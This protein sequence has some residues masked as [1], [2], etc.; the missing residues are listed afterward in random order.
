MKNSDFKR[1]AHLRE[2]PASAPFATAQCVPVG[3]SPRFLRGLAGLEATTAGLL[4]LESGHQPLIWLLALTLLLHAPLLA[5][6]WRR[7]ARGFRAAWLAP[8]G[9]WWLEAHSGLLQRAHPGGTRF[10]T[11]WW[12]LL[13]LRLGRWRA[14]PTLCLMRDILPADDFRRLRVR[15]LWGSAG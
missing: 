10:V 4:L 13:P 8:D 9:T 1:A 12:L 7:D 15:L 5:R 11:A 2:V 3:A 14:G 6:Q